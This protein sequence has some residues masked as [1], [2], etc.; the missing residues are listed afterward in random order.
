MTTLQSILLGIRKQDV[1]TSIDL[2]AA[3]LHIQLRPSHTKFLRFCCDNMHFEYIAL[4]FGLVSA[5][6]AFTKVLAALAGHLR[7]R[8]IRLQCYLDDTLILLS[9]ASQAE[10]DTKFTIQKLQSHGFSINWG[11]SQLE[12]ST[13]LAH[14]GAII[15]T[16]QM[17]VFLSPERQNSIRHLVHEIRTIKRVPLSQLSK[18]LGKLISC[19]SIVPWA[20]LHSRTLQVYLLP[21]QRSGRDTSNSRVLVPPRVLRSLRWWQTQSINRGCLIKEPSRYI[22]MTDASLFGW[23][24]HYLHHTIQGCWS[25]PEQVLTINLLELYLALRK[26]LP[27]ICVTERFFGC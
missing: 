21:F 17:R 9:S 4:P 27:L 10:L 22:V 15:D 1:L 24:A 5:P 26:F 8:P 20:C 6:R 13:R 2:T 12:P 16:N 23:G 11:K 25:G 19:I 3:Y 7:D 18:L 14:L